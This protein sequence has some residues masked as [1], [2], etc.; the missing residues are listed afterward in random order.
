MLVLAATALLPSVGSAAIDLG[1]GVTAISGDWAWSQDF[2]PRLVRRAGPG[3][4]TAVVRVAGEGQS[5]WRCFVEPSVGGGV[6]GMVFAASGDL[7]EGLRCDVGGFPAGGFSLRGAGG[8]VLWSDEGAPIEVCHAYVIEGIVEPGRVRAQLLDWD[9][10]T[11]LSQSPFVAADVGGRTMGLVAIDA[12]A[13]FW[14]F[15]TSTTPLCELTKDAPNLRRLSQDPAFTLTGGGSWM[16]TDGARTRIRQYA[17][18]ERAWAVYR[19]SRGALRQWHSNVRV[20]PGAGGAGIVFQTDDQ[21]H[22]TGFTCWLGGTFGAGCL[23]LYRASGEALWASAED[24]WHYDTD[25]ILVGE[26]KPGAVRVAL[27][28]GSDGSQIAES[29]WV[30]VPEEEAAH[31]GFLCFHTW[32]GSAEFWAFADGAASSAPRAAESSLGD[33]WLTFGGQWAFRDAAHDALVGTAGGARAVCLQP[34]LSGSR[35]TWRVT[36]VAAEGGTEAG[37]VF[38]AA[39]DLSK[40]FLATLGPGGFALYE[41]AR[42]ETPRWQEANCRWTP[43]RPYTIE[44]LVH[45]DRVTVRLLEADG[46]VLAESP[47]T[48][49]TQENNERTGHLGP[50]VRGGSATFE[51]W[52]VES[53]R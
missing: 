30:A 44:G 45:T 49:V 4:A 51:A 29:P 46:R 19:P 43:G 13:R 8:T 24:T 39:P 35:G 22:K 21:D 53:E 33:G 1:D 17:K 28:L 31:E 42:P 10:R 34:A 40:G 38:Q 16:W 3:E 23:M 37:L 50:A 48:Y 20:S 47:A 6:A 41:L 12:A 9:R 5:V 36:V 26:T 18:A 2:G 15:E 11:L 7:S 25:Y 14:G 52:S 27:L 32:L